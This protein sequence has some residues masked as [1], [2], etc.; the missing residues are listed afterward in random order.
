MSFWFKMSLLALLQQMQREPPSEALS[1]G[2]NCP[3]REKHEA[4]TR[5]HQGLV[6][7]ANGCGGHSVLVYIQDI[8]NVWLPCYHVASNPGFPVRILFPIF[9]Q[10]C[11]TKSGTESLGSR[12]VI[13]SFIEVSNCRIWG[14][15]TVG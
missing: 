15:I 1:L 4:L 9:L 6:I 7:V 3:K 10:S 14:L 5:A 8:T 13:M 11:K 12:L 2:C